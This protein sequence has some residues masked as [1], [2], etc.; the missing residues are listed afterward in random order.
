M[1]V[2]GSQGL[3]RALR[4]MKA[5]HFLVSRGRKR[6]D[7]P[8]DQFFREQFVLISHHPTILLFELTPPQGQTP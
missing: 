2:G 1:Q 3:Y 7:L 5:T 8:V 4:Q 6:I